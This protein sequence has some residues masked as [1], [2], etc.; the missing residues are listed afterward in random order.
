MTIGEIKARYMGTII[1][2]LDKTNITIVD[3]SSLAE[4]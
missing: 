2:D 1:Q 4:A 3:Y